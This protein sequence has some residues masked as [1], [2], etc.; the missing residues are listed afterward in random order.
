MNNRY[1][2]RA[3]VQIDARD[4]NGKGAILRGMLYNVS[5]HSDGFITFDTKKLYCLF[6]EQA[7]EDA[8]ES[9]CND[10]YID[11]EEGYTARLESGF[12]LMQFTGSLDKDG[13]EIWEGDIVKFAVGKGAFYT[14]GEAELGEVYF[15]EGAYNIGCMSWERDYWTMLAESD[16]DIHGAFVEAIGNIHENPELLEKNHE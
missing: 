12:E 5:V 14:P 10:L 13:K 4:E 8:L 1:K 6:S 16:K 3:Y 7:I 9:F 2:F 15:S 11:D